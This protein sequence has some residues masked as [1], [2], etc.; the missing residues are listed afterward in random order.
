[1]KTSEPRPVHRDV[2]FR[3]HMKNRFNPNHAHERIADLRVR[4]SLFALGISAC[5]CMSVLCG[6]TIWYL[7]KDSFL[8]EAIRISAM[9][10]PS[11][12]LW[13][14]AIRLYV[15]V[16]RERKEAKALL[17]HIEIFE[18]RY[19]SFLET[20]GLTSVDL[21]PLSDKKIEKMCED[22][23][24][25]EAKATAAKSVR[26]QKARQ[27]RF[28]CIYEAITHIG[29]G[30]KALEDYIKRANHKPKPRKTSSRRAAA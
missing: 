14:L 20:V 15:Q 21:D 5:L 25:S 10:F 1:M 18:A 11:V 2:A 16:R 8:H 26:A 3:Y 12:F 24:G 9:I 22:L 6:A 19:R 28:S 4:Y 23:L 27:K 17:K 7:T 30:K 29:Y 13:P